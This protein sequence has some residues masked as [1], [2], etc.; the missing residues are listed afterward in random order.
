MDNEE[1]FVPTFI[2]SCMFLLE[3]ASM[4]VIS[5]FNYE[6]RPFMKSLSE[7][8]GHFKLMMLPIGLMLLLIFNVSEDIT[9][10]FQTTFTSKHPESE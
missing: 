7:N 5:I 1:E 2:N 8:K 9:G 6:G 10:L 4:F 3:L